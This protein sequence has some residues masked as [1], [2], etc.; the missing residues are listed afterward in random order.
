MQNCA[1]MVT[2]GCGPCSGGHALYIRSWL[3]NRVHERVHQVDRDSGLSGGSDLSRRLARLV[4][5]PFRLGY[6]NISDAG[7]D[8]S[9]RGSS[10]AI[11]KARYPRG[12]SLR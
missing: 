1:C 8:R 10:F 2:D 9:L 4:S 12:P 3:M 5:A 6:G 11:R 7:P